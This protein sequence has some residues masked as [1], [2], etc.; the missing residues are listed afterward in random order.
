MLSC[1]HSS[2]YCSAKGDRG[3]KLCKRAP[4]VVIGAH[5]RK[6]LRVSPCHPGVSSKVW[7]CPSSV[8]TTSWSG[9]NACSIPLWTVA[10]S[11]LPRPSHRPSGVMC[12]NQVALPRL[13]SPALQH[14]CSIRA[15]PNLSTCRHASPK[16]AGG[17]AGG[18]KAGIELMQHLIQRQCSRR[19]TAL[20][21]LQPPSQAYSTLRRLS[22]HPAQRQQ[23]ALGRL[24]KQAQPPR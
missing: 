21:H 7:V 1:S 22:R 11:S 5:L 10:A 20:R 4:N 8:E 9:S 18:M 13:C 17:R 2:Y 16:G 19:T 15:V 6:V 3:C 24:W 14:V 23:L 12:A